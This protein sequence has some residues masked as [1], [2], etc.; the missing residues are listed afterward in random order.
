L[1]AP[2]GADGAAPTVGSFVVSFFGATAPAGATG[3]PG[4]LMRTVSRLTAGCSLFGGNVMRMV[5]LFVTSSD[6]EGAGGISSAIGRM[7]C[8]ISHPTEI[9]SIPLSPRVFGSFPCCSFF[10]PDSL[11]R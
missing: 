6:S 4:T 9:V 11:H 7:W 1:A 5:S 3:L 2:P 8:S 10:A